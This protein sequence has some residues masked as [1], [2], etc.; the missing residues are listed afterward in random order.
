MT[1]R[2]LINVTKE[3]IEFGERGKHCE[4]P[5]ARAVR[6]AFRTR[7]PVG[8]RYEEGIF[9]GDIDSEYMWRADATPQLQRFIKRFD[10]GKPVEPFKAVITFR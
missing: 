3:D 7:E 6:R 2:K 8:V 9:V 4:C 5:I 1:K 10:T